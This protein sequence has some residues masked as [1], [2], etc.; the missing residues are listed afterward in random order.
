MKAFADDKIKFAIVMIFVFDLFENIVGKGEN[1]GI[2]H[3]LL[4][5]QCFHTDF[6]SSMFKDGIVWQRADPPLRQECLIQLYHC[7]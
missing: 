4:F 5:L 6:S 7:P 1:A 2:Q 3:F